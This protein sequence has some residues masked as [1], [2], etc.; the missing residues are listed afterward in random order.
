MSAE[1]DDPIAHLADAYAKFF[2]GLW[3]SRATANPSASGPADA[4]E[5][6][7]SGKESSIPCES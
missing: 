2:F 4:T 3:Q 5:E 6:N 7:S 1:P